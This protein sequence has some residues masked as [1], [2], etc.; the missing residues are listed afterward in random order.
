MSFSIIEL[1]VESLK[2]LSHRI[3]MME[4]CLTEK[5][6]IQEKKECFPF[7]QKAHTQI[8]YSKLLCPNLRMLR[9]P[10]DVQCLILIAWGRYLCMKKKTT[11]II[12]CAKHVY[13]L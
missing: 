4:Y 1:F 3:L 7:C 12:Y 11:I 8:C 5:A 13:D 10:L 9:V 6:Y 2:I